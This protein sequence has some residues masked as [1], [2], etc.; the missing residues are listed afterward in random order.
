MIEE[1]G[2]DQL[3]IDYVFPNYQFPVIIV[4]AGR[5]CSGKRCEIIPE[6][7]E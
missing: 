1:L 5:I 2:L 3:F 6:W 4:L 7:K